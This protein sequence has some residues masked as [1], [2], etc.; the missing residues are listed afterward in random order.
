MNRGG[1]ACVDD[2]KGSAV[3]ELSLANV[4]GVFVGLLGGLVF[5]IIVAWAEFAWKALH[6]A[7]DSDSLWRKM[8]NDIKFALSCTSSTKEVRKRES[9]SLS[10]SISQVD[11][12]NGYPSGGALDRINSIESNLTPPPPLLRDSQQSQSQQSQSYH[13]QQAQS[14]HHPLVS[15]HSIG[16]CDVCYAESSIINGHPSHVS[17]TIVTSNNMPVK[18]S[19]LSSIGGGTS[20]SLSKMS[21]CKL[22]STLPA[23]LHPP[24]NP[25]IVDLDV[26]SSTMSSSMRGNSPPPF[27]DINSASLFHRSQIQ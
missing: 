14:H 19:E 11:R 1:G 5:S 3:N 27:G 2:K 10:H 13:Q 23:P 17:T 4:G 25:P 9:L 12:L 6:S 18:S 22:V 15:S 24:P 21:S 20:S 8:L 7:S 16:A 26:D